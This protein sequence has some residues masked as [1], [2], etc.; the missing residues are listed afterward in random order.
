LKRF[1][2]V[3]GQRLRNERP[4]KHDKSARQ[5]GKGSKVLH[6][7]EA[8]EKHYKQ[9]VRLHNLLQTQF[10]VVGQSRL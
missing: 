2:I 7:A 4:A 10:L 5:N 8:V 1:D 3:L 9:L 6:E